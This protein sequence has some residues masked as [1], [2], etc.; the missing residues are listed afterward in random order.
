[1]ASQKLTPLMQACK[2]GNAA[3]VKALIAD[4]NVVKFFNLAFID[5]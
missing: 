2:K 5:F 3:E 1:M 4:K